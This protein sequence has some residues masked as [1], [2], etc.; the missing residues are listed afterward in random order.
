MSRPRTVWQGPPAARRLLVRIADL[1]PHPRN[2]R[3]HDIA[4]IVGS[5]EA[6]GQQ[7]PIVCL[8]D[9]TIV[10]G[11]GTV[12]GATELG[13]T[14]IAALR[15]DLSD[16]EIERYLLADNRASDRGDYDDAMLA[17]I[18]TDL[19]N[20]GRL[21]GT[22]YTAEDLDEMIQRSLR[23]ADAIRNENGDGDRGGGRPVETDL[24]EV[25]L[26][27]SASR[28]RQLELWRKVVEKETGADGWSDAAYSAFEL[29]ARAL[30]TAE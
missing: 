5:L 14:H 28:K 23:Q 1:K 7:R 18:L 3:R 16:D 27:Y 4:T 6:F 13:W 25:V 17:R 20:R 15:S 26:M 29:A 21:E 12:K 8:L 2:P 24:E 9:G 19:R 11:H 22:G 10:A 30:T